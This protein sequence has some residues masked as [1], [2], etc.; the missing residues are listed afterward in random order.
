MTDSA[1]GDDTDMTKTAETGQANNAS[2][3]VKPATS[4]AAPDGSNVG[5]IARD[6]ATILGVTIMIILLAWIARTQVFPDE[7]DFKIEASA[8]PISVVTEV[9]GTK[10]KLWRVNGAVTDD[11]ELALESHVMVVLRDNAGN[12]FPAQYDAADGKFSVEIKQLYD[13]SLSAPPAVDVIEIHARQKTLEVWSNTASLEL[14]LSGLT[15][16][17]WKQATARP[18]TFVLGLFLFTALVTIV[19]L[20]KG[21]WNQL[22][23]YLCISLALL[24]TISM[25][26]LIGVTS[27]ELS[28][29]SKEHPTP[30]GF[31][32]V[33]FD[34]YVKDASDDWNFSL[35]APATIPAPKIAE[36]RV[37]ISSTTAAAA[38]RAIDHTKPAT[39]FGAPFWVL[40]LS[41]IGSGLYTIKLVVDN[42]RKGSTYSPEEVRSTAADIIQH[43]FYI[44]FSPLG[45][46]FV[47]QTL[48][49]AGIG[50][51]PLTVAIAAL[52][53]GIALN[54]VLKKAWDA[55]AK[56]LQNDQPPNSV[57]GDTGASEI[58]D[59]QPTPPPPTRGPA[60]SGT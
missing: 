39:G 44:L 34:S 37:D 26:Y 25:V 59:T 55:V 60:P 41:V 54:V 42:V 2:E 6:L 16:A 8:V 5:R 20:R 19:T 23:Y 18:F 50:T 1:S 46:I 58:S 47:Y 28:N 48:L 52:A 35:T 21:I 27:L 4:E 30:L 56:I 12:R 24:F 22:K 10:L 9:D 3:P 14:H 45:S 36:P 33:Y 53:S 32:Y 38:L 29:A 15:R 57:N 49:L 11:G 13:T 51:K 31:A 17:N 40:M 43:Q 7:D